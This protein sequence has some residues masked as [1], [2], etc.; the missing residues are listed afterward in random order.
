MPTSTSHPTPINTVWAESLVGLRVKVPESWWVNFD[1][2]NLFPGVTAAIDFTKPRQTYFQLELDSELGAYY[3]MRYDSVFSFADEEQERFQRFR[4]PRYA[5]ANPEG[6][7]VFITRASTSTRALPGSPASASSNNDTDGET[8][9]SNE[10]EEYNIYTRTDPED[11]TCL[12]N[13]APGRTIDPVPY[14]GESEEFSV[15]ITEDELRDKLMDEHGDI[16]FYKVL[17]WCLPRFGD[18]NDT[19]LWDWQAERMNN[20]MTHII[21][22]KDFKPKYYCPSK[23]VIITGDNVCRFYGAMLARSLSGTPSVEK[24]WDTRSSLR[25]I[26]AIKESMPQDAFK[27][28]CRCMHFADDWEVDDERWAADYSGVKEEPGEETAKH[29]RKFAVLEDGYNK[30]WQAIVKFGRWVT[31]D[32]SRI[33]GWYH[34]PMT[35]GP[36]PKPIRTG[37]T[38]HSLCV[39]HGP[40]RTFKLFVRAYGGASDMDLDQ[41]HENVQSTQKWVKLYDIMLDGLKGEGRCFTIDSAYMGDIMAQIGRHEWKFNMIGTTNDN[42]AGAD[43]KDERKAMKKGTYDSIMYQHDLG[44]LV[45][46]MWSNNTIVRTLSNLHLPK[47]V[48]D[49]LQWERKVNDVPGQAQTPVAC[50]LQNKDYSETFHLIDKGNG[51]KSKYDIRLESHKHGWSPKLGMRYFNMNLNNAYQVYEYLVDK[52]TDGRRYYVIGK[53]VDE[54]VHAFLQ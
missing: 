13:G 40:L 21:S 23:G 22:E 32:E 36:E 50:P 47:V 41:V 35:V 12:K 3:P 44:G 18:F 39:T 2:T 37:C 16:R 43:A 53:A 5:M 28:L 27:D 14:T 31:A 42:R 1:G 11:W 33:A 54:A 49:G 20:Y 17:E 25:A 8:V 19:I 6:E 15:D 46:A 45:F 4:L 26:G 38:L 24:I 29:R 48:Q 30:R 7:E 10:S 34:S 9:A 52:Y 51:T